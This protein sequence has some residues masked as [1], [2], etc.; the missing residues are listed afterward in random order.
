MNKL[1]IEDLDVKDKRVFLRVDFNVPLDENRQ[2]TDDNRIQ[3]ALPTIQYL[4]KNGARLILVSHLGRPKGVPSEEFSLR[5]VAEKLEKM[6]NKKIVFSPTV[7]GPVAQTAIDCLNSGDCLLMENIRFFPEEERNDSQFSKDLAS[8]A[9]IYVND[10]FG[11]AHRAHASTTGIARY[12]EDAACGYL[13]KKELDFLGRLIEKPEH[14][15]CAIVGGAKVKDKI[16]VISSLLDKVDD[17]LIGG[18]M[19]YTFLKVKEFNIGNSILDQEH[20]DLVKETFKKAEALDKRIH[21]PVDH[22]IT[23]SFSNE[24]PVKNVEG[25]IP[26]GYMGMDI[27]P[28]TIE[29][30][31]KVINGSKMIFWNGPMGVFEM[32]NFKNGTFSMAV[33]MSESQ[34]ITVIG[35]GDSVAAVNQAGVADKMSH[36]STGGGASLRFIQGK[37]L[38]GIEALAE[39]K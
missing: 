34:A 11:T 32:S 26:E 14:P 3:A 35:G 23:E 37:T 7:V 38:P 29:N 13:M 6:L 17:V 20:I 25:D 28:K 36:I 19:A 9:D 22:V 1:T 4:L 10:A 27:G 5:P 39:K 8:L 31:L 16:D 33:G 18:G 24:V 15:F 21:L 12:F 2:V 30:Y